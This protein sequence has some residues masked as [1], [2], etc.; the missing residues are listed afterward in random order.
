MH[1]VRRQAV[2]AAAVGAGDAGGMGARQCARCSAVELAVASE[3]D[4]CF[5][6]FVFCIV[7]HALQRGLADIHDTLHDDED[8]MADKLE[9]LLVVSDEVSNEE[10]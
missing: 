2:P 5:R 6:E 3:C 10:S 7:T 8:A 9:Q 1:A 4:V